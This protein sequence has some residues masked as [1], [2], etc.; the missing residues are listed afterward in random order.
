MNNFD[1]LFLDRDGVINNKIEGAY[2]RSFSEFKFIEGALHAVSKLSNVFNRIIIV[3]N[4]Q[5]IGKGLM[6]EADLQNLHSQMLENIFK[7]GGKIDRIYHCPHLEE[8]DCQCR[9][10]RG[11]MIQQAVIDFPEIIIENSFLV[12]DSH[13]DIQAGESMGLR[14]AKVDR[15]YTLLKWTTGLLSNS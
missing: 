8:A 13:S 5:G 2:V 10:P 6:S 7:Y 14:T 11:G 15:N 3:T 9:K 12:G 1:T 4:Q